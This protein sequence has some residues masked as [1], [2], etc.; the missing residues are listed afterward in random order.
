[1]QV[2]IVNLGCLERCHVNDRRVLLDKEMLLY[3]VSDK[4]DANEDSALSTDIIRKW[5]KS[6]KQSASVVLYSGRKLFEESEVANRYFL[7][8][9]VDFEHFAERTSEVSAEVEKIPK[10]ILGYF[11]FMDYVMD[12]PLMEEVAKL[13]LRV[14][15]V[16]P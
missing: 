10:P 7:E 4:Y 14:N 11:G 1:M 8:Q 5:D 16:I 15:P 2:L 3:Q 6:L 13:P 9:A 12:V